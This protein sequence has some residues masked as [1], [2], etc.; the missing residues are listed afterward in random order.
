[1]TALEAGA[2]AP[3]PA[4]T[5][6]GCGHPALNHHGTDREAGCYGWSL[7]D[8]CVCTALCP[9]VEA[10]ETE[11]WMWGDTSRPTGRSRG[12]PGPKDGCCCAWYSEDRGGGYFETI[13]EY[14][15]ACPE[16]SEHVYDPRTG[17][18][19]HAPEPRAL[20]SVEEVAAVLVAHDCDRLT[21]YD[22]GGA[23]C[24]VEGCAH[25]FTSRTGHQA[26]AVLALLPG[27]TEAEIK[28][29][30]RRLMASRCKCGHVFAEHLTPG[31]ECVGGWSDE[32][33]DVCA[34]SRFQARA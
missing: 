32:G 13:Q 20:P 1:M 23:C 34:C 16:H 5:V 33:D 31:T 2:S 3:A 4:E 22:H 24:P 21:C 14:D 19:E 29:E 12:L 27:R 8:L 17:M 18:W 26:S 30:D 15:P 9:E 28:A 11:P 10:G 7:S 25:G 6:C